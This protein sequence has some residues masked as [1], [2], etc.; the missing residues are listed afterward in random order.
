MFKFPLPDDMISVA[1]GGRSASRL[2]ILPWAG[3]VFIGVSWALHGSVFVGIAWVLCRGKAVGAG[4]MGVGDLG[5]IRSAARTEVVYLGSRGGEN[6]KGW[7]SG[8]GGMLV[9]GRLRRWWVDGCEQDAERVFA[10]GDY[11]RERRGRRGVGRGRGGEGM[12][13]E[14]RCVV[15]LALDSRVDD[16]ISAWR[17]AR[18]ALAAKVRMFMP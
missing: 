1:R 7:I 17:L 5:A 12:M 10:G 6:N 8:V 15:D 18:A 14:G 4:E 11:V 16:G 2:A 3:W 13:E 9:P